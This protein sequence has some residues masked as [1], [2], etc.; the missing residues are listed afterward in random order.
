M[1]SHNP[2]NP[3]F[4]VK[5]AQ[6]RLAKQGLR[7]K[8]GKHPGLRNS[9]RSIA[10]RIQLAQQTTDG[11][12]CR[13]RRRILD[14]PFLHSILVNPE[15]IHGDILAKLPGKIKKESPIATTGITDRCFYKSALAEILLS[16][17]L[18]KR[19]QKSEK[20]GFKHL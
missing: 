5:H 4:G 17:R 15:K 20:H 9:Q 3:E 8:S 11:H 13:F 19:L 2:E 10:A 14:L 7:G 16:R 18:F 1:C 6:A 12:V